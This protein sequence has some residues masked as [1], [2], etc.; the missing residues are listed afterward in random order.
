MRL[1]RRLQWTAYAIPALACLAGCVTHAPN[2]DPQPLIDVPPAYT[3]QSTGAPVQ[4]PWWTELQDDELS[5]LI[6]SALAN[7]FTLAQG[8]IRVELAQAFVKQARAQRL[9]QI[10]FD[11]DVERRWEKLLNPDTSDEPTKLDEL[12]A[13]VNQMAASAEDAT[14][15]LEGGE[16]ATGASQNIAENLLA[17]GSTDDA[18]EDERF[19]YD[20]LE[21]E[22]NSGIGF[23]WEL[24]LWGRLKSLARARR[25]ELAALTLEYDALRL[26]L[27]AQVADTYYQAVEQR[28]QHKLLLEQRDLAKTLLDLLELRFLQGD[29]SVVDVLQQRDQLAEI[30]TEIPV[31]LSRVGVQENRMDVLLGVP[32]DGKDRTAL[33]ESLFPDSAALPPV[34]VPLA[35]LQNRPDLK[36]LQRLAVA[37]D[38]E[39]AAAIAERLPQVTLSGSFAFGDVAGESR[40]SG[41][42]AAALLQPLV[43][44]GLRK[45][46]VDAARANWQ[47]LLLAY[48]GAYLVAIEEVEN[49]LWQE[50]RQR[51]RIDA[52]AKREEILRRTVEEARIRYGLGVTDYLP[53]LTALQDLQDVQRELILER[54]FLV[55]LRIALYRA[56]GSPTRTPE[57]MANTEAQS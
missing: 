22:F 55:S 46:A 12:E 1:P 35:L 20:S 56:I 31:V 21:T 4:G 50:A 52:L 5:A 42:G 14:A 54:R 51:E 40:L 36:S 13:L 43:D 23:R 19:D 28:M 45:A 6:E 37:A 25:E 11:A 44:W 39:I 48:T 26:V 57:S 33:D 30:D 9:P 34:G 18:G 3:Q 29:A 32:P 41:S 8:L 24:D 2:T 47:E 17:L 10:G 49:S 7:N 16:A 38:H 53:V 27:S 15:L